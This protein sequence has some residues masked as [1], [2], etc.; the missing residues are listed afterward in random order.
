MGRAPKKEEGEPGAAVGALGSCAAAALLAAF[1]V[2]FGSSA[3][4]LAA[5]A[6]VAAL[7]GRTAGVG[8]C[9]AGVALADAGLGWTR[10]RIFGLL[11]VG[12]VIWRPQRGRRRGWA[13]AGVRGAG[14][15]RACLSSEFRS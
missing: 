6:P 3:F 4:C 14:F 8:R 2:A 13:A 12:V 11:W 10:I 9:A 1:A 15:G 5:A 7:G